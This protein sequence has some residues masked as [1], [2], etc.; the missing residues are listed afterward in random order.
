MLTM[1]TKTFKNP[2]QT[3]N[4][5]GVRL[6]PIPFKKQARHKIPIRRNLKNPVKPVRKPYKGEAA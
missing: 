1:S 4:L 3:A 6:T 2:G 5:K